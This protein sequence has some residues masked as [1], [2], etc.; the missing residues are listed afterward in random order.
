MT[1]DSSLPARDRRPLRVLLVDDSA[2]FREGLAALL[3]AAGMDVVAHLSDADGLTAA[4]ERARPQVVVLD[5][6]MPP[7][8]TD[9]GIQAALSVRRQFGEVGVL[10]LSTYAEGTWA[11][12]LF[13]GGTAGV[14]YLLKDR[15][16]DTRA[17]IDALHRIAS[18]GTVVDPEVIQ[19]LLTVTTHRSALAALSDRERDVLCLMAQGR[20]NVGIGQALHLSPRTVEAHIASTFLKLP[21]DADDNTSNRRILAVLAYLQETAPHGRNA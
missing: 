15:V 13:A 2:L 20:S 6:R 11:S 10:V 3:T 8:H 18:G 5:A 12:R 17:L 9:E 19:R 7:T 4:I 21:L 1:D 14:G 16:D